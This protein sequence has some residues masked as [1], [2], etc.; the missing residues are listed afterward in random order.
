MATRPTAPFLL[1]TATLLAAA[2]ATGQGHV[3]LRLNDGRVVVG[4]ARLQ[5]ETYH[6]RTRDGDVQVAKRS[7]MRLRDQRELQTTLKELAKKNGDSAFALVHLARRARAFGLER[8]MWRYLDRAVERLAADGTAATTASTRLLRDFLAQLEPELLPRTLRQAPPHKRIEALLRSFRADT[9]PGRAAALEELLVREPAADQL[10]RVHAR[11]NASPRQ[12]IA[13]LRAL[14]R[15]KVA[16]NGRFVLRTAVLDRNRDVR[17][18]A[19]TLGRKGLAA[20]DVTYMT[21]GLAHP[22]PKV[23]VRTA[24]ALGQLG[25][26]AAIRP[27][28]QAGPHAASGLAAGNDGVTTRAHVAFLQQTAYIRDFDVEVAQ[29][30]FIADPRVDVLQ[31]GSVLDVEVAGVYQ[32]RRIVKAYRRAL[33]Q[34]AGS[35]PGA[36]PRRWAEW[37]A[38][39]TPKSRP[40]PT[41]KH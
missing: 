26:P 1:F 3:E 30:A 40:A 4:K 27:L 6:V 17:S 9:G 36:D 23:R 38:K 20:D 29:A 5:N 14:Q 39:L 12:R 21:G 16:G 41:G 37:L 18:A 19:V 22:N 2:G 33:K 32:V 15:R 7:V 13:A 31:S 25:H 24:E 8:E 28:V 10:L 35:D 11:R 34:L